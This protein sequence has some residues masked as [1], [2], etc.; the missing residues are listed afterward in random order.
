ME[1]LAREPANLVREGIEHHKRGMLDRAANLY[2]QALETEPFEPDALHLLGLIAHQRGDHATAI[3]GIRRAIAINDRNATYHSNL[4]VAYRSLGRTAEALGAFRR[5][6]ELNPTSAGMRFNLGNALKDASNFS[7]AADEFRCVLFQEPTRA[8]AWSGLG[9]AL[10]G[11]EEFGEARRCHER[12]IELSPRSAD[13]HYNLGL[14]HRDE[15]Q[16]SGAAECF[17]RAACLR[18][19]FP[20]A[21]VNL[22]NTYEDLACFP[23]ALAAFDRALRLK[24]D[25]PLVQFN[26]AL[27]LLR[28]GDL[29]RG[30]LAYDWRWRHNG[31]PRVFAEPE[32]NAAVDPTQTV[33]VYSEQGIGDE[34]MFAS[35][36]GEV[37]SRSR[38]CLI[39]CEP[40]LLKLFARSFPAATFFPRTGQIDPRAAG[41]PD[42][43]FQIPAGSLPR[44]LRPRWDSFPKPAGYLV[45][46]P[47]K[48]Q[49]WRDRFE[50]LGVGLAVG[51]AWRGGKDPATRR[52][53]ST[54]LAQWSPLFRIPGVAFVNLQYGDCAAELEEARRDLAA[55]LYDWPEADPLSDL[56]N[57]AAQIAALDLVISV[58]NAAVHMAGALNIPVWT[59][60]PFASDWRWF[61]DASSSPW[62]PSM[63]LFRQRTADGAPK[64]KWDDVLHEVADALRVLAATRAAADHARGTQLQEAGLVA[65]AIDSLR[66]A[67][68]LK[69]G[70]SRTLN[71]LGVAWKQA[72]RVELA[73]AA[74]RAALA[75]DPRSTTVWFNL[76]NAYRETNRLED[77]VLCYRHALEASPR[78]HKV[79]VNLA[80]A[81]KDLRRFTEALD[82]LD[83]VLADAPDLAAA[84]FDRSLIGLTQGNFATGWDEYECRLLTE[85]RVHHSTS[86]VDIAAFA[87][88]SLRILA[89]Q[90]IGDQVMFASCL[91]EISRAAATCIVEC[92]PRLVPLFARS[93]PDIQV[94]AAASATSTLNA[95]RPEKIEGGWNGRER[96]VSDANGSEMRQFIGSLPRIVRRRLEDFPA[97][98]GFLKASPSR[99]ASW[100]ARLNR[101]GGGLKVGIAWQGG[102]DRETQC[103]RTI[104]LEQ[105]GPIFQTPGVRFFNLQHGPSAA[106][107]AIARN[108]FGVSL[109]DGTDCDPLTDLDDFCAKIAALDLVISADNSTVHLAGALGR[110]V[111]T[112]LPFSS[113]WRWMLES[114]STPWYP[115]MRLLRCR[116]VGDWPALMRRVG[117][118]LAAAAFRS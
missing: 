42:W 49:Q 47:D 2:E 80:V 48:V 15:G 41:V 19:D 64:Q 24:P 37:I 25:A 111:W 23:Q 18:P 53:R 99:V 83:R 1:A 62:Y 43:E 70:D 94:V 93:F 102:K 3:D 73:E 68:A 57:Q 79:L 63:R 78:D 10:R 4:G 39:E 26:R 29:E 22:A 33:L 71:D 54:S 74:Y 103:K 86:Q 96:R 60:L 91:E 118:L 101:L 40:R 27:A 97:K 67:A 72:G 45:P 50:R 12:A 100:R 92:N 38:R 75:V 116:S 13:V 113:D 104:P 76:G 114:E 36:F 112:L 31:K 46:D 110:P 117:R 85:P 56:D 51:I 108:R 98:I 66:R 65:E 52:R 81:L 8:E 11:M 5:A 106:E 14:L 32:W 69:P 55:N 34:V 21:H 61:T 95:D 59:L 44:L 9:D 30:W 20:D 35:C 77:A 16:L 17:L 82:C 115:T 109:D 58:D 7:A 28:Q 6:L 88:R 87:G 89:E 107:A 84:R 105:W 90:G